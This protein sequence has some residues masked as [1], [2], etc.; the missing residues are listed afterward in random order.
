MYSMDRQFGFVNDYVYKHRGKILKWFPSDTRDKFLSND[1]DRLVELG[2]LGTP[3]EYKISRYGLRH[4][5]EPEKQG[6]VMWVG[7]SDVFGVGN[8]Y[9]DNYTYIAHHK[10][11]PDLPYYNLG[12]AGFG[13]ETY[14]RVIRFN[15]ERLKPSIIVLTKTWEDSRTE[16]W[17]GKGYEHQFLENSNQMYFDKTPT[18]VRYLKNMDAIRYL[19]YRYDAEFIYKGA[20]IKNLHRLYNFDKYKTARDLHH[21]GKEWNTIVGNEYTHET[22]RVD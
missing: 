21:K 11:Y 16:N 5:N 12:C 7:S 10:T 8:H 3:I 19:C 4:N 22:D 1:K 13:I 18:S 15:I 9:T 2:W 20:T 17:N 14:Y 6:G